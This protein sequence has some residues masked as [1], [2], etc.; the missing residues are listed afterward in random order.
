MTQIMTLYYWV[1]V[2]DSV[3][4]WIKACTF[5][6]SRANSGSYGPK[7]QF[8]IFYG[9]NASS[10]CDPELTFYK[11]PRE[12]ELRKKWLTMANRDEDS[13]RQNSYICSRHFEPSCYT[14]GDDG[15]M[16]LSPDAIPT[17]I[18]FVKE[19]D[20]EPIPPGEDFLNFRALE[21]RL[22]AAAVA[23][24]TEDRSEL[25]VAQYGELQ[26]HQY[27]L[28][29]SDPRAA[30]LMKDQTKR[31]TII[32]ASFKTYN[33]IARYLSQK[34]IPLQGRKNR[35]ALRRMA[36]RFTLIDGELMYTQG[37]SRLLRVPRSKK[38]VIPIL[39]Q[40]H[41]NRGH[42]GQDVCQKLIRKHYFWA[43]MSRD[44]AGWISSCQTCLKHSRNKG[45]RCSISNCSSYCGPVERG[46]GLTFH[47]FPL[48][49]PAVLSQWLKASGRLYWRPRLHSTVCSAH[50][51]DN[52][53][54]RT[55][56]KVTLLPG[57]VPTLKVH[58]DS[59][60]ASVSQ[61]GEGDWEQTI[62]A[63]YDAVELYLSRGTYPSGL[64]YVEKNTF[65]RFCRS[66]VI[67]DDV[68]HT[69]KGD[70]LRLVLRNRQQVEAALVDFHNELNH[71]GVKKCLRLLNE[72]YFWRTMRA[73]VVKW[74]ENCS[75]CRSQKKKNPNN[76]SEA[77]MT[78][79]MSSP[80]HD[81]DSGSDE[82]ANDGGSVDCDVTEMGDGHTVEELAVN[83]QDTTVN[84][85]APLT[86]QTSAPTNPQ[87][88]IPIVIHLTSQNTPVIAQLCSVR[89]AAPPQ[90]PHS[91]ESTP[92][93]QMSMRTH[94]QELAKPLK[95]TEPD[96]CQRTSK[97]QDVSKQLEETVPPA[98]Q[99]QPPSQNSQPTTE[100]SKRRQSQHIVI[101]KKMKGAVADSSAKS[102]SSCGVEPIV[103]QSNKPWPV[104][105][106]P[107]S[108][109][110]Q[111]KRPPA[112]MKSPTVLPKC[113]KLQARTIIQQCTHAKVKIK[114]A[115]DGAHEQWAEIKEGLVV[116]VCFFQ[117]A[118][119]E[120]TR[121][122]ANTLMTTK[123]FKKEMGHFLS[124][125]DF[126]GSV[127]FVPQ[128]SLLGEPAANKK[129][130]YKG[131]CE[132]WRGAQL[133]S[134]LVSASKELMSGSAK[135]SK[136][137]VTV[138]QGVYGQKQEIMLST[139]EPLTLL[140]EF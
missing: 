14:L 77:E 140:L 90:E 81:L 43:T 38:E 9:C 20:E 32:E 12:K 15:Q 105:T 28:P 16:K 64:S 11:F 89:S 124:V 52:C 136:A 96:G 84:M 70:R 98:E 39:Q 135:C 6:Q 68:L 7:T 121:Q 104:F 85:S 120:V 82:E 66:F 103:A 29:S 118:A 122:M 95:E 73:D 40:F 93:V 79:E 88:T 71:L 63:K 42:V 86:I 72:R 74:I 108:S 75:Q 34:V 127:L 24:E 51:T 92:G 19:E 129:V 61:P 107:D 59:A 2:A 25:V 47:K 31:K 18:A 45:I 138:K 49:N 125:L 67:K 23:S 114:P 111:A 132:A 99:V 139:M 8:C 56:G 13:W 87:P 53:F 113:G 109:P 21:E 46:L 134:K 130:Q 10:E 50:F 26:E 76:Q 5:C 30:K 128:D 60:S 69:L 106:I 55:S 33:M 78:V 36:K 110:S 116:Y 58:S 65:R 22:S 119:D 83:S 54:D 57:A 133:F 123:F 3:N 17:V 94:P 27:C 100:A 115:M 126:P 37:V 112:A 137:D 80:H 131:G 101:V 41:D 91:S 1:G 62:F 97:A 4:N 44:V 48:N 117:G 35:T 102:R